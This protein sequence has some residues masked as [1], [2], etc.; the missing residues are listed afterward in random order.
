MCVSDSSETDSESGVY[1]ALLQIERQ[2]VFKA[3]ET[4]SIY[5]NKGS[6][7][8]SEGKVTVV[9][10]MTEGANKASSRLQA[11]F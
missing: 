10:E 8:I 1:A 6:Q 2:S 7:L 3:T 11:L 5:L 4:N 9:I